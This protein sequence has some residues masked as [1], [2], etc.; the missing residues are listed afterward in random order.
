MI[1]VTDKQLT[2]LSPRTG[3]G[4]QMRRRT[5]IGL[6]GSAAAWPLAANAQQ[7]MPVIGFLNGA[8]YE[9]SAYLVEA[10]RQGLGEAGYV[11]SRNVFIEY[12]SADGQYERLPALAADL[13]SVLN[14]H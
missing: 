1:H 10:F 12:R 14:F 13:G 11:E 8:S 6:V 9:L 3:S 7:P 2:Q 4:H 5:F